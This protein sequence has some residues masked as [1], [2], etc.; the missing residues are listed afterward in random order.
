MAFI[1][2]FISPPEAAIIF[3]DSLKRFLG[4]RGGAPR[5]FHEEKHLQ[6]VF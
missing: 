5:T 1:H 4:A 3:G 6:R 2:Y